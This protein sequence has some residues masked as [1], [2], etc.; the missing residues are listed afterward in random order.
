[1]ASSFAIAVI[2][3]LQHNGAL[4]DRSQNKWSSISQ[5]RCTDR[6]YDEWKAV[7]DRLSS[8]RVRVEVEW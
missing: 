6:R 8:V 7:V 2:S 1:M 5:N 3:G 4:I